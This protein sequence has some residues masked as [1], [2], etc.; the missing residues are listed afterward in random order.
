MKLHPLRS[1]RVRAFSLI[2][3]LV[4]I[5]IMVILVA[6]ATLSFRGINSSGN[7]NKALND[8]SGVLE[9]ARAYA[10]AQ[11]TYVWVALYENIP[12]SGGPKEVYV[13]TFASNDGTD[14][15][16][17]TGPVTV[18][19]PPGTVGSTGTTLTQIIRTYHYKGLHL[20]TGTL[21]NAPT[22]PNL[23]ATAS[24]TPPAP[25]FQCTAQSDSG[26]VTLTSAGTGTISVY[27]V[28]QF[29]PTGAARNS[30]NTINSI[31]FGLQPS[32]SKTVLDTKNIASMEV[33]GLTG[34]TTVYRQ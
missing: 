13:G 17:W 33:N 22:T 10:V 16:N 21:P 8:I 9:Q 1:R 31:W 26:P 11:D 25:I 30:A 3:L 2:E 20:Q 19:L 32:L 5:A 6:G 18:T 34:L 4:V 29:T 23:P 24:T 28:V 15:F 12:A 14:P 27:W 7:F